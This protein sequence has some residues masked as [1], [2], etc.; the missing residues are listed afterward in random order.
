MCIKKTT[1]I[2][3]LRVARSGSRS[4]GQIVSGVNLI[5]TLLRA[6]GQQACIATICFVV[7]VDFIEPTFSR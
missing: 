1:A 5:F 4:D 7:L 6:L 2:T 3:F